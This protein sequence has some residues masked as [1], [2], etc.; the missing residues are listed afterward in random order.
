MKIYIKNIIIIT[1]LTVLITACGGS[2]DGGGGGGSATAQLK[3]TGQVDS[4]NTTGSII[5]DSSLKDNGYYQSGKDS[6]YTRALGIVTDNLSQLMWQD[7]VVESQIWAA[8]YFNG[9]YSPGPATT[10]CSELMLG[11]YENWRLPTVE[12]LSGL[13]EFGQ[14]NPAIN[15]IFLNT[16]SRRYWSSTEGLSETAAWSIGFYVDSANAGG[17]SNL[18]KNYDYN[19]R[20]VRTQ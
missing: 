16:G 13:M 3:K 9:D 14:T 10:Y 6:N 17:R 5:L 15:E 2:A 19:I 12:E 11:G 18:R 20:C 7:D 1:T 8:D 4:Y